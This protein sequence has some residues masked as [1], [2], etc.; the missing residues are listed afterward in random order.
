MDRKKQKKTHNFKALIIDVD[1]TLVPNHKHGKPS[2]RVK[3]AIDKAKQHLH[4]SIASGRP[5]F[6]VEN[7]IDE[8]EFTGPSIIRGGA[9]I[10]DTKTRSILW[11]KTISKQDILKAATPLWERGIGLKFDTKHEAIALTENNIPHTSYGF[12]TSPLMFDEANTVSQIVTTVPTL[13]AHVV[14][15]WT[16]GK[17]AVHVTHNEATK[18]HGILE[19]AKR[20]DIQ[21]DE[22]IGIGDG[23]ND[24]PLLMA[25]GFRVAMGNAV[26]DLKQIADYIAP[27]VQEDGV[28]D[29]IEKFI[30]SKTPIPW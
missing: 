21:T 30:L 10:I 14:P 12:F 23:G 18:Q 27:T 28:A 1:G 7:L 3:N 26:D 13:T 29:V 9:Q 20:L 2:R 16:V 24:M 4:V 8:L 22:I 11:E 5:L 19:V 25:C 17:F 15:D 6:L